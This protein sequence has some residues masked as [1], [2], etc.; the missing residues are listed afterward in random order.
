MKKRFM[1]TVNGSSAWII[2]GIV[3]ILMLSMGAYAEKE[4]VTSGYLGV[5]VDDLDRL[6]K[7]DMGI[8]WGILVKEVEEG[9]PAD[10][11][12]ILE[13][14]V[15][16]TYD[17][18][19]I[20]KPEDLVT[21][22]RKTSPGTKVKL[23]VIQNSEKKTV[24]VQVGEKEM[25]NIVWNDDKGHKMIVKH[26]QEDRAFLGVRMQE[27]NSDLAAYFDAKEN[28]G[29]LILEVLDDSPAQKAGLK[30]GDVIVMIDKTAIENPESVVDAVAGFDPG[31][32]V[33]CTAIRHGKK[34]SVKV[35]L[36]QA[37][38]QKMP[39]MFHMNQCGDKTGPMVLP[40]MEDFQIQMEKM[41]ENMKDMDKNIKIKVKRI[42]EPDTI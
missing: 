21:Q 5:S 11:A 1:K 24:E 12:G 41:Q 15:I 39:M 30:S 2:S 9:S 22:V 34:L 14:D 6:E 27:L 32:E 38:A 37:P 42:D 4:K 28:S 18:K 19:K 17:G 3:I 7:E 29:A 36:G 20:R 33:S 40:D 23:G 35:T 16:Q 13:E 8:S 31:D 25:K 26:M 10:K